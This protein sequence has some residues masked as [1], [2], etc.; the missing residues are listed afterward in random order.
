MD[1]GYSNILNNNI[2]D[3]DE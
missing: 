1:N 3:N 2:D